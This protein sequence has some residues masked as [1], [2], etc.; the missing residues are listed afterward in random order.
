MTGVFCG[1]SI[2]IRVRVTQKDRIRPDRDPDPQ[3]CFL[4]RYKTFFRTCV[5]TLGPL[6]FKYVIKSVF[7]A[8][9]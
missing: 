3:H 5:D 7:Q 6:D 9:K 2:R 8:T 1:L 4:G